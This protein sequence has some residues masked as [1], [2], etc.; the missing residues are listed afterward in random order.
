M[1]DPR[2]LPEDARQ[3]HPM[4]AGYPPPEDEGPEVPEND[5]TYV[6]IE[7]LNPEELSNTEVNRIRHNMGRFL[8]STLGKEIEGVSVIGFDK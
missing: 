3:Y 8:V 7:G 6:T 4:S 2:D 5:V 1:V